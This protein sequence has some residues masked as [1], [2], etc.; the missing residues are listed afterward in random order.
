MSPILF[1][2]IQKPII[3]RRSPSHL[4]SNALLCRSLVY[5]IMDH[6]SRRTCTTPTAKPQNYGSQDDHERKRSACTFIETH[7]TITHTT[8][9]ILSYSSPGRL[10]V[11]AGGGIQLGDTP[12]ATIIR[13]TSEE[14]LLD[15]DYVAEHIRSVGTLPF[16]HRQA[17]SPLST[18]L[19]TYPDSSNNASPSSPHQHSPNSYDHRVGTMDVHRSHY[20][21]P[22]LYFLYEL[23]LP[24]D[25]SVM[26]QPNILDGEV[27]SFALM[28]L[29]DV[30]NNLLD[31]RFKSSSAMAVVDWLVRHGHVTEENDSR[32]AEVCR[33]LRVDVGMQG[34][35]RKTL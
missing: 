29:Q 19:S 34:I 1:S 5:Q 8:E 3:H 31:G 9:P 2:T 12:L 35:W 13:E 28:E 33:H 21:L 7:E 15:S 20:I 24:A 30:L 32:F 18:S 10:D 16:P 6:C 23:E 22:G 26:P 11:T 14:A 27:Q 4:P 17:A 25:R